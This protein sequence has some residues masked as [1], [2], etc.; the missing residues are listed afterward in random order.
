V[1]Q[2]AG[3]LEVKL[4][5][6]KRPIQQKFSLRQVKVF[7]SAQLNQWLIVTASTTFVAM[8]CFL[9]SL[10]AAIQVGKTPGSL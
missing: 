3:V 1:L 8:V 10:P 6:S 4:D 5:F 7:N 9:L 2:V